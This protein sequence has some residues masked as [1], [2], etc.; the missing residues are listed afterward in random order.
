VTSSISSASSAWLSLDYL[1]LQRRAA[2]LTTSVVYDRAGTGWSDPVSLPRTL[3]EVTEELR[4]L[5]RAAD[6][7]APYLLVGHS[8]GGF[9]ARYYA[10][11]FPAEVT[12]MVLMEPAH[13]DYNAYM[14][15]ELVEQWQAFDPDQALPDE[16][17]AE[18]VRFY[19]DLLGQMLAGWPEDVR[20][21]LIERHVSPEWLR[22]GFREAGNQDEL[23]EQMRQAG[24]APDVPLIIVAANGI[25]AFKRAV[26]QGTP[27]SLLEAE[28]EGKLRLYR[29]WADTVRRGKVRVADGAGHASI[30]WTH[31]GTV[32]D[33]IRDLLG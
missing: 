8:L 11:R 6:V 9:Y 5:L 33:A 4:A 27:D 21:P 16:L 13:E 7:P 20:E 3:A 25:D 22:T 14:P 17:P 30:H 1:N 23:G 26:S 2:E 12:G 18:V 32:A 31:P 29:A 15:R 10:T 19:R 28:I 24:P